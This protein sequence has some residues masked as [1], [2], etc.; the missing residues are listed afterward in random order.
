MH[1]STI[2]ILGS[3]EPGRTKSHKVTLPGVALA[4]E[5]RLVTTITGAKPGPVPFVGTGV[6]GCE[7]PAVEM[8]IHLDTKLIAAEIAGTFVLMPVLNVAVFWQ[9]S[10]FVRP[11]DEEASTDSNFARSPPIGARHT[12]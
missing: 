7:Y 9:R 4:D 10:S 12:G 6:H 5:A 11:M 8:V 2:P 1:F 3:L